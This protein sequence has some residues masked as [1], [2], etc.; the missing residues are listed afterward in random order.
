MGLRIAGV[1]RRNDRRL[2][3]VT[4]RQQQI[5]RTLLDWLRVEYAI[6]KPSNSKQNAETLKPETEGWKARMR[7]V[8]EQARKKQEGGEGKNPPL[9]AAVRFSCV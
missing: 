9:N 1:V 2:V 8:K 4:S 7:A 6:E 5:Q 3:E